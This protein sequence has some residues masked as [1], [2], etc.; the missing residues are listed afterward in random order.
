MKLEA[1]IELILKYAPALLVVFRQIF[2]KHGT[3]AVVHKVSQSIEAAN[4]SGG[5]PMVRMGA[6]IGNL[7]AHF[8]ELRAIEPV[9]LATIQRNADAAIRVSEQMDRGG[10]T[11]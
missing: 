11:E 3:A 5:D 2:E 8:P 7:T 10:G 1:I 9:V 6:A 4:A